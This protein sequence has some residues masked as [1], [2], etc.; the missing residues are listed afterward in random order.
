MALHDRH[1]AVLAG[2]GWGVGHGIGVVIIGFIALAMRS[3]VDADAVSAWSEW[4]VGFLLLGVGVWAFRTAL[5]PVRA[6]ATRGHHHVTMGVGVLHGAAGGSHLIG[7]LPAMALSIPQAALY[8]GAYLL[9][10][11]GAMAAVGGLLARI[12]HH[13]GPHAVR[14]LVMS[15]GLIAVGVGVLWLVQAGPH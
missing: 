9:G 14:I 11:V 13:S 8:L 3:W 2:A 15:A 1:R 6:T 12:A 5:R 10:A 7:V 4:L